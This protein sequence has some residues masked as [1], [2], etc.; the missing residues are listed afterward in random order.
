MTFQYFFFDTYPGYFLQM[1]PLALAAG[2]VCG[3]AR[4]SVWIGLLA[5]YLAGLIGLTVLFDLVGEVWYWLL[6]GRESGRHIRFF[7]MTIDLVPDFW[8]HLGGETIGNM[9][10]L[11][12]FGVLH[13]LAG[14]GASFRET[15]LAGTALVLAIECIQPIFG[16]AFDINDVILNLAGVAAS[17]AVFFVGKRCIQR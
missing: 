12:P 5:A 10:L 14:E 15:M 1:L 13:P 16:R 4:K 2:L 3:I 11:T 7:A 9:L 6:Y 17:A 8:N